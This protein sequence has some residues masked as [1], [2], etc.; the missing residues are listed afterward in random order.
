MDAVC[1]VT[2]IPEKFTG[3]PSGHRAVQLWDSGTQHYFL[4]LFCRPLRTTPCECERASG[5]SISQALHLM[6]SPAIHRKLG[7]HNGRIAR[8]FDS[9]ADTASVIEEL[10]L[11]AFT[12]FPSAEERA[13]AMQYFR[14]RPDKR[15]AAA[16]DL[17][18]SMLNSIEFVFNH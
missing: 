7:H 17:L 13:N 10:Y 3:V 5:A 8:L 4:S 14:E 18:W 9:H 2:G 1:D 16:E 15:Q 11:A 6:N 12:R